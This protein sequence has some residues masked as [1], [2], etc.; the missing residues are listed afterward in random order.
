MIASFTRDCV[1]RSARI[2]R[3]SDDYVRKMRTIHD[4][5]T[6]DDSTMQAV[7]KRMVL[8]RLEIV[9]AQFFIR[10]SLSR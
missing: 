9:D 2:R 4:L 6:R 1:L 7:V 10:I 8:K 5:Q 3:R